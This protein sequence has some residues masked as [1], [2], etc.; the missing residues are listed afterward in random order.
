[1]LARRLFSL[2]FFL[3]FCIKPS[4]LLIPDA[5]LSSPADNDA[6][7]AKLAGGR[8]VRSARFVTAQQRGPGANPSASQLVRAVSA[9]AVGGGPASLEHVPLDHTSLPTC[10]DAC[11]E[12]LLKVRVSRPSNSLS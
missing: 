3:S 9:V 2:F 6:V 7:L 1:M 4:R 10:G 8:P 12:E 11:M 5:A